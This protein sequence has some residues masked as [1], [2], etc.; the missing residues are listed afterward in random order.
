MV[1]KLTSKADEDQV[2]QS[3][4]DF[5]RLIWLAGLGAFAKIEEEGSRLFETLVKE[6]EKFETR[7]KQLASDK[8]EEVR[9][10]M[11]EVMDKATDTWDKLEEVFEDRVAQILN[12]IGVPTS[13]DIEELSRRVEAL[14]ENVRKLTEAERRGG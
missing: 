10:R 9:D 6:G 2:T 14:S 8:V 5:A 4:M 12:R 11:E 1:K 3:I 13:E 7:T